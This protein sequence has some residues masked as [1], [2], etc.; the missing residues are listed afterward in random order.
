MGPSSLRFPFPA[1]PP[2]FPPAPS[3]HGWRGH[4]FPRSHGPA[5]AIVNRRVVT[6]WLTLG[7][8]GPRTPSPPCATPEASCLSPRR[9]TSPAPTSEHE[10]ARAIWRAGHALNNDA[11]VLEILHNGSA[12]SLLPEVRGAKVDPSPKPRSR[13][14][15]CRPRR[16]DARRVPK[17]MTCITSYATLYFRALTRSGRTSG[18]SPGPGAERPQIPNEPKSQADPQLWVRFH[19]SW[20]CPGRRPTA[21][22]TSPGRLLAAAQRRR[23]L[24]LEEV[25]ETLLVGADLD[26]DDVIEAGLAVAIDRLE[27][28]VRGRAAADHPGH[29]L[30]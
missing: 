30:L 13:A 20:S 18:S 23:Q 19:L 15:R 1:D 29:R 25:A 21:A 3:G 10:K 11:M 16:S 2:L 9:S 12:R 26:Q 4:G 17:A 14:D 28:P 7:T 24:A 8:S 27:M 22:R 5:E 6:I